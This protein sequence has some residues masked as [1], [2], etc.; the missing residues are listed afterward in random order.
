MQRT[1]RNNRRRQSLWF[2]QFE[3]R[4]L[5]AGFDGTGADVYGPLPAPVLELPLVAP[6]LPAASF[7]GNDAA[8]MRSQGLTGADQTVVLIDSGIAYDHVAL[9]GGF[10]AG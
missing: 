4:R 10:G 5:L 2:E 8:W 9:G 6:P 1:A 3:P 7:A